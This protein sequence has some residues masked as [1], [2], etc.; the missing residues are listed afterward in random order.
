MKL[1]TIGFTKKKAEVFFGLLRKA[2]V[3]TLIDVRLNN[4][5]QL[6][7]YA[8]RDDL[9]FFLKELCDASYVHLPELSPTKDILDGYKK[10][11]MSWERYEKDYLFLL[12]SRELKERLSSIDLNNS[13]LLCSEHEPDCCH[14]RLAAEYLATL[15]PTIEIKHLY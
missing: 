12:K 3:T 14:R 13:C 5:S 9:R 11:N 4:V 15:F 6:A 7:G 8:K 2:K 1:Y 10:G